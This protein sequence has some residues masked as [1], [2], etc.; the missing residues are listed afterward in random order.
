MGIVIMME[1]W[2]MSVVQ[3]STTIYGLSFLQRDVLTI[4]VHGLVILLN[5]QQ[6]LN[7]DKIPPR[8]RTSYKNVKHLTATTSGSSSVFARTHVASVHRRQ[9]T[10]FF[11]ILHVFY[12]VQFYYSLNTF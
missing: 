5:V 8:A 6:H 12:F 3:L 1:Y 11:E 9:K 4:G 7:K 2:I 10:I